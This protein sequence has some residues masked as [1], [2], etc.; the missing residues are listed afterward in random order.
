M[1]GVGRVAQKQVHTGV[2]EPRHAGQVG[3]ATVQRGLVEFDVTGVQYGSRTGVHRDRQRVGD[4][5]V[6]GEVFALEHAVAAALPLFDFD[7]HRLDA[8]LAAFGGDHGQGELGADDGNVA[9][10][11]E[12]ERDC[13]D[14][15]FVGV[16]QHQRFDV[17]KPVFDMAQVGQNQVDAGLVMRGEHHPAVD[18]QQPAQ[19]FE[20]GHVAADF[21]D[22]AQC[23][24]P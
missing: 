8:V 23:R 22:A 24:D 10:Q 14:V 1:F 2:A 17:V 4:G 3:G 15:V 19:V 9:P 5:V 11:L 12:Q 20:N 6:D 18:D 21:A 13:P 16:R 7:E